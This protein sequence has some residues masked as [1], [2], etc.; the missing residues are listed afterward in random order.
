MWTNDAMGWQDGA[1]VQSIY[2]NIIRDPAPGNIILAHILNHD[3]VEAMDM[4]ITCFDEQ[5][6]QLGAVSQLE[7]IYLQETG[8]DND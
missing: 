8:K 7:L 4:A 6:Y 5:G 2:R 3:T 1:T